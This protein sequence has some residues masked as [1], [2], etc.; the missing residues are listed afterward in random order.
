MYDFYNVKLRL[1]RPMLGTCSEASI[2]EAH[3]LKR[4]QKEIKRAN[5]LEKKLL[6]SS[7]KWIGE[8]IS[9]NK[10]FQEMLGIFRTYKQLL[11][12]PIDG[13]G[14]PETV[15]EVLEQS[16]PLKAKLEE[17]IAAS[18]AVSASVFMRNPEGKPGIS[19][20]MILGNLKANMR[21]LVNNGDKSMIKSK[22]GVGET[23]SLDV[24]PVEAFIT[25]S[26]DIMRASS[27]EEVKT[28][29]V[30]GGGR[31]TL[32]D[33]GRVLLERAVLMDRMGKKETAIKMSEQLPVGT[34]F[35]FH[36]RVR[37]LS[38]INETNLRSLFDLGKSQG[39]GEWRGSGGMGS[40]IYQLERDDNYTDDLPEGWS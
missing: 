4:A 6:K 29:P 5:T 35:S 22:V 10:E 40:F 25:A 30:H 13:G 9:E 28:L 21:V 8:S 15:E 19:T 27:S 2:W 14:M 23:F 26:K 1:T 17:R 38:P 3:V 32:D 34:E 18:Q 24:K 11:G 12:E 16:I 31:N 37:S 20:H 39:L 36:L 33:N 7:D